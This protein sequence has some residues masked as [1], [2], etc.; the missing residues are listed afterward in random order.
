MGRR[1]ESF[2]E[3]HTPMLGV[4]GTEKEYV[5]RGKGTSLSCARGLEDSD[6]EHQTR[7]REGAL[8]RQN[9]CGGVI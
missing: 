9:G 8:E 6:L 4:L 1:S 5:L 2:Q 3:L 7:D